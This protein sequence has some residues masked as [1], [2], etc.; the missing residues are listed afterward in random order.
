MSALIDATGE[1]LYLRELTP[2]VT[3]VVSRSFAV[4]DGGSYLLETNED[5]IV[6]TK[7]QIVELGK[8]I[9]EKLRD[10]EGSL[11]EI[12]SALPND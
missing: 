7:D 1:D 12:L 5:G 10:D 4:I 8:L 11:E 3:G 6:L 2:F 9:L